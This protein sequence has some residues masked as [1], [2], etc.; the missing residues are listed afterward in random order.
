[1]RNCLLQSTSW[2]LVLLA[3]LGLVDE[4]VAQA[5]RCEDIKAAIVQGTVVDSAAAA[6]CASKATV[7]RQAEL[8]NMALGYRQERIALELLATGSDELFSPTFMHRAA[9]FEQ[10]EVIRSMLQKKPE[11]LEGRNDE[12]WTPLTSAALGRAYMAATV[13]LEAGAT[14]NIGQSLEVAVARSREV[15]YL[16]VQWR[17]DWI[18]DSVV[19]GDVLGA[20]IQYTDEPFLQ[21]LLNLGLEPNLKDSKGYFAIVHAIAYNA[22]AGQRT[23]EFMVRHGSDER[24][25]ICS[26]GEEKLDH[27]QTHAAEWFKVRLSELRPECARRSEARP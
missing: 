9:L 1:M 8:L 17:R 20:A 25:A 4:V 13:L 12:G 22:V 21:F 2:A 7:E 18:A 23:W 15:A 24:A 16:I 11:L 14:D 3:T 6:S 10:P 26:L 27:L 19:A 5:D